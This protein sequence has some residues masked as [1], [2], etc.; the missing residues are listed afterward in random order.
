MFSPFWR[1]AKFAWTDNSFPMCI[2]ARVIIKCLQ[3]HR[4][5]LIECVCDVTRHAY[6]SVR[7]GM[8]EDDV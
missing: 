6:G 8:I 7:C 1:L 5:N 4:I 3:G 2:F